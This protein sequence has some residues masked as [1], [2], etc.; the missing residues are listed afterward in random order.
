MI[1]TCMALNPMALAVFH[2]DIIIKTVN[3]ENLNERTK[4]Y[5]NTAGKGDIVTEYKINQKKDLNQLSILVI[6]TDK[7]KLERRKP[8][9]GF[10]F[11]YDT[12]FQAMGVGAIYVIY[13]LIEQNRFD[14]IETIYG[15]I[16]ENRINNVVKDKINKSDPIKI[17][18]FLLEL[19]KTKFKGEGTTKSIQTLVEEVTRIAIQPGITTLEYL[20]LPN[21]ESAIIKY[22]NDTTTNANANKIKLFLNNILKYDYL[23][24]PFEGIYINENIMGLIKYLSSQ[25]IKDKESITGLDVLDKNKIKQRNMVIND[26]RNIARCWLMS[27]DMTAR[28]KDGITKLEYM[29]TKLFDFKNTYNESFFPGVTDKKHK[30][31]VYSGIYEKTDNLGDSEKKASD[32]KASD[33]NESMKNTSEED[34]FDRTQLTINTEQL[35]KQQKHLLSMYASDKLYNFDK[36]LITD[37]LGPF[38]DNEINSENS[39]KIKDYKVFYL[40]SNH[41]DDQKKQFNCNNQIIL[42]RNTENFVKAI[43]PLEAIPRV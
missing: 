15:N 23:L 30:N 43:G 4:I 33:K 2:P 14:I 22:M 42:L 9:V 24:T 32:T 1:I 35:M 17:Y 6:L 3:K 28:H 10:G 27:Q 41:N 36:P 20:K 12:D 26:Q 29:K 39:L 31:N 37:I 21:I 19:V 25:L 13:R 11:G 7:H 16:V 38:I 40:F 18:T 5:G 8:R 34:Q